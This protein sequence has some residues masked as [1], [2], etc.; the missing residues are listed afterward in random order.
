MVRTF[1]A[2]AIPLGRPFQRSSQT[3]GLLAIFVVV[4]TA[5]AREAVSA[6][7]AASAGQQQLAVRAA[8]QHLAP[9]RHPPRLPLPAAPA[10][11]PWPWRVGPG[12]SQRCRSVA[13]AGL[14]SGRAAALRQLRT[15][16]PWE[17]PWAPLVRHAAR[18]SVAVGTVM[19]LDG[20]REKEASTDGVETP[21]FF[22][23]VDERQAPRTSRGAK[24][25]FRGLG[26]APTECGRGRLAMG[27]CHLRGPRHVELSVRPQKKKLKRSVTAITFVHCRR[28]KILGNN[29]SAKE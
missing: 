25:R 19:A 17:G 6:A 1:T 14:W 3:T 11:A 8:F 23:G 13:R 26:R 5:A 16:G 9:P 2:T 10:P 18:C 29:G 27:W 28:P 21:N 22:L 12:K 24:R 20:S 7:A 15:L 4:Q